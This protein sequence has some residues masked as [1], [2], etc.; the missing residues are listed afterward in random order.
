MKMNNYHD[1]EIDEEGE[2]EVHG[3]EFMV[4]MG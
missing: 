3:V 1:E 2:A 4:D